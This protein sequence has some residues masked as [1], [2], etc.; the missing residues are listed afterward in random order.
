MQI[1]KKYFPKMFTQ[2]CVRP[3]PKDL[4]QE[5]IGILMKKERITVHRAETSFLDPERNLQVVAD[6]QVFLNKTIK[7]A[8]FTKKIIHS[9]WRE[10]KRFAA[11][12]ADI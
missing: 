3:I 10:S 9:E 8:W 5:N 4:L 1:G 11:V 12:A 7:K 6:G 2:S